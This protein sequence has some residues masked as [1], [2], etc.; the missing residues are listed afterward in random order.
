M[1]DLDFA[2][3]VPP[4]P[5]LQYGDVRVQVSEH[6]EVTGALG[7]ATGMELGHRGPGVGIPGGHFLS[8]VAGARA[9]G[10]RP[11]RSR[12]A[13]RGSGHPARDVA[14]PLG[15]GGG[16]EMASARCGRGFSFLLCP[17]GGVG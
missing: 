17:L 8:V 1:S 14:G 2:S 4:F 6:W 13:E 3:A 16:E 9:R 11:A 12:E 7:E 10:S 5:P 15:A